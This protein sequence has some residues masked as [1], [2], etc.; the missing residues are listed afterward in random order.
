MRAFIVRPF[1]LKNDIDFDRVDA[2]LILPALQKLGIDGG[3][4]GVVI[5]AGSTSRP[6]RGRVSEEAG[7]D[8]MSGD[9]SVALLDMEHF[10]QDR[11]DRAVVRA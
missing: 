1:G 9:A 2:E 5:E 6:R 4:T 11:R 3:T 7:A 8:S 10:V